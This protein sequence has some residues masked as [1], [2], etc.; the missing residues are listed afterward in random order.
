MMSFSVCP[1]CG[2][3]AW[4]IESRPQGA[5]IRRVYSCD[6]GHRFGTL[7]RVAIAFHGSP[8]EVSGVNVSEKVAGCIQ[9]LRNITMRLELIDGLRATPRTWSEE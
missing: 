6:G 8:L 9:D 3:K 7:E 5:A 1:E 4:V 2:A